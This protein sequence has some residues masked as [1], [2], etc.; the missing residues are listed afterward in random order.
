MD[1]G[2]SNPVLLLAVSAL[3]LWV[4]M[5]PHC[6]F[7]WLFYFCGTNRDFI[8]GSSSSDDDIRDEKLPRVLLPRVLLP[9][10]LLPR[11]LLLRAL[12]LFPVPTSKFAGRQF[13]TSQ[14]DGWPERSYRLLHPFLIVCPV[15]FLKI[16]ITE[17]SMPSAPNPT[18]GWKS[19]WF[20]VPTFKLY[21]SIELPFVFS[22]LRLY[23]AIQNFK[24][25]SPCTELTVPDHGDAATAS[26]VQNHTSHQM[27]TLPVLRHLTTVA[28]FRLPIPPEV[29]T[30][31]LKT[32]HI[33][34]FLH[35]VAAPFSP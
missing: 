32:G 22:V 33:P 18:W 7:N 13:S 6:C 34:H 2:W 26:L 21:D 16:P 11:V 23:G 3:Y 17:D 5:E 14:P 8:D 31:C 28:C 1:S 10:V 25:V 35:S 4:I 15:L 29:L 24:G 9:R 12:C 27:D 30:H 19:F 20:K